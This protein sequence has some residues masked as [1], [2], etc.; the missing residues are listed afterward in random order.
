MRFRKAMAVAVAA[1]SLGGCGLG[2]TDIR[3]YVPD[4]D[5]LV[6][7]EPGR[8]T[9]D[10]VQELLGSPASQGVFDAEQS[11]YYIMRKTHQFA[12]LQPEVLEQRVVVVHFD[13]EGTLRDVRRYT[14]RRHGDRSRD[15]PHA[16]AGQGADVPRT[17]SRQR[18][19][20]QPGGHRAR[21]PRP[22]QHRR[23][24][25]LIAGLNSE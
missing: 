11:W 15:A 25:P 23:H 1:A 16:V 7:L 2:F 14:G 20:V 18:R 19:Q 10:E 9:R 5:R 24:D 13:N 21:Q 3:G 22:D 8:Q 6:R 4:E 12:F 17:A